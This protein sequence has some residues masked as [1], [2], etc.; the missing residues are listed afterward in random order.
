MKD[1]RKTQTLCRIKHLQERRHDGSLPARYV[2]VSWSHRPHTGFLLWNQAHSPWRRSNTTGE[3]H[4]SVVSPVCGTQLGLV[5]Y[6]MVV[7][8]FVTVWGFPKSI[9]L[10][11]LSEIKLSGF[12]I[13]L[14]QSVYIN[15]SNHGN[16]Q[17][18]DKFYT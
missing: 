11:D 1:E 18:R 14:L 7:I 12:G 8:V 3:K 13:G 10:S 16:F 5:P 6:R 15:C 9:K 17:R 4:N 2:V